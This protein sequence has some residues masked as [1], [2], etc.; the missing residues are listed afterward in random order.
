[1]LTTGRADRANITVI[2][3]GIALALLAF[4]AVTAATRLDAGGNP[5][6][7]LGRWLDGKGRAVIEISKAG[8]QYIGKIVWLKEP[9]FPAD[10]PKGMAG[11]PRVDRE[12]PDAALRSRP[13]LGL[14]IMRGF[15]FDG[16]NSWSKGRIYDP[17]NGKTYGGKM[18]LV[19]PDVLSLRG[20]VVFSL[21]GRTEQWKRVK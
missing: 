7:I 3:K 19:S 17:Q 11:R 4:L 6:A 16:W 8:G 18:S 12:N 20:F 21:F 13:L 1:M 9:A 2:M 5:D 10:D 15:V 14:V